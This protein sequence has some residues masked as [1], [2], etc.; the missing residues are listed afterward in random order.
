MITMYFN[1]FKNYFFQYPYYS[2]GVILFIGICFLLIFLWY[3]PDWL[4]NRR[5]FRIAKKHYSRTRGTQHFKLLNQSLKKIRE[6]IEQTSKT[7]SELKKKISIADD[8]QERE[9]ERIITNWIVYSNL[10]EVPGIGRKMR[11]RIISECF[12]GTLAS[13]GNAWRVSGVGGM[14]EEAIDDWLAIWNRKL[15][16]LMEQDFDGRSEIVQKYEQKRQYLN[17]QLILMDQQME[18]LK[19]LVKKAKDKVEIL[20][21]ITARDFVKCFIR[22]KNDF[23]AVN[24]YITG[25]FPGWEPAP[26]WYQQIIDKFG[27]K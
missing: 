24:I 12:D 10:T 2:G 7:I 8:E 3:L 25:V 9:I 13:I 14:K 21:S 15:P 17:K 6:A 27:K 19:V 22:E 26:E 5:L 1:F 4:Y 23:Q 20:H 11:D 18:D 16:G